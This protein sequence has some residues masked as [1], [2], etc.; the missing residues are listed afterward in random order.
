[1]E[2]PAGR[3]APHLELCEEAAAG[4]AAVVSTSGGSETQLPPWRSLNILSNS[5]DQS[6]PEIDEGN[7]QHTRDNA[8]VPGESFLTDVAAERVRTFG[9][10]PCL[11][12]R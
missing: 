6:S 5:D 12:S 8:H 10:E 3:P 1:M 2:T 9:S 4:L 7:K 11:Q